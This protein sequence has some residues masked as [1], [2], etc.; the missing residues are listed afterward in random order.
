MTPETDEFTRYGTRTPVEWYHFCRSMEQRL[1]RKC[2]PPPEKPKGGSM[3]R[4]L[5]AAMIMLAVLAFVIW[6]Y[7]IVTAP[8]M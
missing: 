1:R 8:R 4:W 3:W 2:P 5:L 6:G 7:G